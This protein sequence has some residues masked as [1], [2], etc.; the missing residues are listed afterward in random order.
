M[1]ISIFKPAFSDILYST[2]IPVALKQQLFFFLGMFGIDVTEW[3]RFEGVT[4]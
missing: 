3:G 2:L 1:M 4:F